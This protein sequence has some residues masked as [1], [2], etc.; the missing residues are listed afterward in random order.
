LRNAIAGWVGG[1]GDACEL[2]IVDLSTH[3]LPVDR[4][5]VHTSLVRCV[6]DDIELVEDIV[7]VILPQSTG[8]EASLQGLE[9][10]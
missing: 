8:F 3:N 4:T 6:H 9:H 10:W 1:A 2:D 5:S 7:D